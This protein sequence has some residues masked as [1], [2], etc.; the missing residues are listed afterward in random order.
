MYE[1]V[2]SSI[3]SLLAGEVRISLSASMNTERYALEMV[4]G[5][6]IETSRESAVV[7]SHSFAGE[8]ENG[9]QESGGER[10]EFIGEGST[11]MEAS[12]RLSQEPRLPGEIMTGGGRHLDAS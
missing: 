10:E 5:A 1:R 8:S 9:R 3:P 6:L 2:E 11:E 12:L 4:G 7:V